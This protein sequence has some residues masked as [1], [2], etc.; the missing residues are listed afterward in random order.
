MTAPEAIGPAPA[1]LTTDALAFALGAAMLGY[2]DAEFGARMSSLAAEPRLAA[3]LEET[4]DEVRLRPM[5]SLAMAPLRWDDLR[6]EYIERFERASFSP[7]SEGE[8]GRARTTGKAPILADL[9][10]FYQAF[11]FELVLAHGNEL[12]DHLGVELEFYAVLLMKQAALAELGNP[13]GVEVVEAARRA[14]L[15]DHLGG[16]VRGLARRPEVAGPGAYPAA[17]A[18]IARLVELECARLG[19]DPAAAEAGGSAEP[20]HDEEMKCGECAL[21]TLLPGGTGAPKP[22][23][24]AVAAR[25]LN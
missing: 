3:R 7:L 24:D 12:G 22:T 17:V 6:S 1:D 4:G 8:Y 5:L 10:G 21:T 15:R 2:P 18:F 11:G 16:F 14:F 23:P 19:V 25:T 13:E 20:G 9:S